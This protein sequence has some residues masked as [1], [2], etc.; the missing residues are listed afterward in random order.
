MTTSIQTVSV[1]D[2][3]Q[4]VVQT[5]TLQKMRLYSGWSPGARY[6]DYRRNQHT[7]EEAAARVGRPKPIA[8][9]LHVMALLQ[10]MLLNAYGEHWLVRG[11]LDVR[12]ISMILQDDVITARGKVVARTQEGD[13]ARLEVEVWCDNN[14]DVKVMLGTALVLVP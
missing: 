7:D 13:K 2:Q 10:E 1:G 6:E 4:P 12:C 14:Q 11:K 8:Q 9:C 3:L 5:M